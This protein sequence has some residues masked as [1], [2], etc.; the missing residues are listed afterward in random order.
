M[1]PTAFASTGRADRRGARRGRRRGGGR[2]CGLTS[3]APSDAREAFGVFED[4]ARLR[5]AYGSVVL[6][7]LAASV[8]FLCV[9]PDPGR[10]S[11]ASMPVAGGR[12]VR[13]MARARDATCRRVPR[14]GRGC[15]GDPRQQRCRQEL[16]ASVALAHAGRPILVDD[17]LVIESAQC[18]AGPRCLDLRA[19]A[20]AALGL[21][22]ETTLVTSDQP[23]TA[24]ACRPSWAACRYADS[25][26]STGGQ[27][28]PSRSSPRGAHRP[29][30]RNIAASSPSAS[31][32]ST[33]SISVACRHSNWAPA[34]LAGSGCGLLGAARRGEVGVGDRGRPPVGPRPDGGSLLM[35]TFEQR[36]CLVSVLI[37]RPAGSRA[38]RRKTAVGTGFLL[39]SKEGVYVNPSLL[40]HRRSDGRCSCDAGLAGSW[41]AKKHKAE[42]PP[43]SRSSSGPSSA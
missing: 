11:R 25:C 34:P 10:R 18:F 13:P 42:P 9:P 36:R 30:W 28:S 26:T 17:L 2:S 33:C 39:T 43:S 16:A 40:H 7:R 5:V 14:R 37:R 15:L 3:E 38:Q 19:D 20:A 32:R 21:V 35:L 27:R 41:H 23:P 31:P 22:A 12:R 4:T 29:N 6:E 8:T 24:R 1:P